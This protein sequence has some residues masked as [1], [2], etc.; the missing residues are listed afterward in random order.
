M[1]T[2]HPFSYTGN[3]AE[4]RAFVEWCEGL[5]YKFTDGIASALDT[6][7]VPSHE[8]VKLILDLMG[9]DQTITLN[10]TFPSFDDWVLARL[11][12]GKR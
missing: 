6:S 9:E 2:T 8:E 11:K 7:V 3:R 4:V 12:F 1:S 10:V 5:G